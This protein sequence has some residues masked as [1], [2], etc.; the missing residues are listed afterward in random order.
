MKKSVKE[1]AK[2]AGFIFWADEEWKPKDATIDWACHSYDKELE[3]FFKLAVK[4]AKSE[5]KFSK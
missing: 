4:H 5:I 1:L 3:R 2:K